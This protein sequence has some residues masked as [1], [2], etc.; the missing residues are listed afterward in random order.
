MADFNRA[1]ELDPKQFKAYYNR[2][3]AK[4][5]AWD[6]NGALADYS[7]AIELNPKLAAAWASRGAAKV[8]KGDWDGALADF[9]QA[10]EID[11]K[12]RAAYAGRGNVHYMNRKWMDA[13]TE[14]RRSF[15]V[16]KDKQDYPRMLVWLIRARLN[17]TK[18]ADEEL[19]AYLDGRS[20]SKADEWALKLAE[21]L[22]ARVSDADLFAAAKSTGPKEESVHLCHAWYY[23]GMKK[24]LAGDKATAVGDFQKCLATEERN[25]MVYHFAQSELQALGQ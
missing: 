6:V 10:L 2:G 1:I 16:S 5:A 23:V 22:L 20:P 18:E 12:L 8:S 13:L 3:G 14:Y 17:E 24:L 21:F 9:N 4:A 15:E 25:H 19:A 11:P 7:R